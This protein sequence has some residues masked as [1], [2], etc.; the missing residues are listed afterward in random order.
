M[1]SQ[2]FIGGMTPER[3]IPAQTMRAIEVRPSRN[4]PWQKQ[5]RWEFYEGEG[6]CPVYCGRGL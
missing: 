4:P 5:G 6:V 2:Y 1:I 3:A